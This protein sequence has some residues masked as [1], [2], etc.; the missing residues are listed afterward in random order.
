MVCLPG[1]TCSTARI[2][3]TCDVDSSAL[4]GTG[5]GGLTGLGL[6]DPEFTPSLNVIVFVILGLCCVFDGLAIE[7]TS[8][9]CITLLSDAPP[10]VLVC[11]EGP[12]KSVGFGLVGLPG[13]VLLR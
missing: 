1:C 13:A 6:L 4:V 12:G 2:A 8:Q 10:G 3:G 11:A 5:A 9:V 7:G